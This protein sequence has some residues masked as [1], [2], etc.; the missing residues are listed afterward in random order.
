MRTPRPRTHRV[1][2]NQTAIVQALR[3]MGAAAYSLTGVG[4]GFPDL[5]CAFRGQWSLLEI[6]Q[7]GKT[8]KATQE[9]WRAACP[10]PVYVVTTP[11]EAMAAVAEAA[12]PRSCPTCE[13]ARPT[14][15]RGE[16]ER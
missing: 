5:L 12:R 4:G 1:D 10:C 9:A 15:E 7:P 3:Q 6:K 2:A 16:R 11:A 13:A 14:Q 8:L